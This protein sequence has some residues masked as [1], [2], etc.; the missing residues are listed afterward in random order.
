MRKYLLITAILVLT[1]GLILSCNPATQAV[2]LPENTIH[3]NQLGYLPD[4][5]KSAIVIGDSKS[6]SV[7][8]CETGKVVFKGEL[9]EPQYWEA[10][11]ETVRIADFSDLTE[12]G[13]YRVNAGASRS[14][15]FDMDR[16]V[17][18]DVAA[19]SVK[20]FYFHRIGVALDEEHAGVYA[21][22]AGHPDTSVAIHASAASDSRPEGTLISSP[23]GWYDAGDFNKYIVNSAIT[24]SS[25]MSAYE[26]Y[27]E[28]A[29]AFDLN[30]PESGDDTP[31]LLDEVRWNL[32]WMLTMQDPEDGGVYHK[33]TTKKF[34]GMIMPEEDTAQRWV[35]MKTTPAALDFAATMA[36]ASRVYKPFDEAFSEQC[37]TAALKAWNWAQ[38]NEKVHYKQPE[39]IHTGAYDQPR[40]NFDD[41]RFWAATE[42]TITTGNQYEAEI[43][44]PM[45]VPE[46]R[47]GAALTA[48]NLLHGTTDDS[49]N[50]AFFV[51]ADSL[52]REQQASA[53]DVSNDA[54]RWG[55]TSD[56][57]NQSMVLI[58]AYRLSGEK[59]YKE[60]AQSTFDWVL[61]KNP[62][63]YSFVT[64]F[65]EKTAMHIH[66]R[67]SEADGVEAP[68]PGWVVGGPNPANKVD[69]GADAYTS[70]YPAL[71]FIDELCS[72]AT[73]EIAINW[74]GV[75]VYVS[76]ALDAEG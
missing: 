38:D 25:M 36:Q 67:P 56:F 66:H 11:G 45:L 40:D 68:Q 41:E 5:H 3:V 26:H 58:S 51:L 18:S 74:N 21:R 13:S 31:D 76:I 17:Y 14:H 55:S 7:V 1:T 15:R 37:L 28:V 42:L 72:Y 8:A 32:D 43:P 50:Q 69:C 33:L 35:L 23:K 39:D 24:V 30:I 49:V 63:G 52:L 59:V 27:P 6:F 57:L 4:G 46:W 16:S 64:G 34:C 29:G 71:A 53:Y 62:T 44:V 47:D 10:S 65:G 9:G 2:N 20:A 60:A 70:P 19:A 61:G 12:T 22:A 75:F 73:N 48:M 54:F